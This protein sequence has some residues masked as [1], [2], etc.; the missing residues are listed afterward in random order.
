[1]VT[2]HYNPPKDGMVVERLHY[3][4]IVVQDLCRLFSA[5][6]CQDLHMGGSISEEVLRRV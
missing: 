5:M 3:D 2:F 6:S 4:R 1:M